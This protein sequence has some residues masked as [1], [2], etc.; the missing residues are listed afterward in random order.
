VGDN[1]GQHVVRAIVRVEEDV[2]DRRDGI[3][4]P[5]TLTAS[6][7]ID[8]LIHVR[9]SRVF[10][11]QP[12]LEPWPSDVLDGPDA[13]D[14]SARRV[15]LQEHSDTVLAFKGGGEK[16]QRCLSINQHDYELV[17]ESTT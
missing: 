7:R 3:T 9:A 8:G 11:A 6:E 2:P 10:G 16:R 12:R 1:R 14:D 15:G 17:F 4:P 13:L 5:R